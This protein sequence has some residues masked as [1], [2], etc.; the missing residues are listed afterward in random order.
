MTSL[1]PPTVP[2]AAAV[3]QRSAD[4]W[5]RIASWS[6][7]GSI[8]AIVVALVS[9]ISP[10]AGALA[11]LVGAP[12]YYIYLVGER[13]TGTIGHQLLR[14]AVTDDRSAAPIGV[15]RAALRCAVGLALLV[16]FAVTAAASVVGMF[17]RPDRRAWHDLASETTVGRRR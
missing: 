12:A 3:P 1:P 8:V 4:P 17:R 2:Q 5:L 6:I 7:D 14:I 13:G 9:A 10:S 15:Q 16:P 11:L